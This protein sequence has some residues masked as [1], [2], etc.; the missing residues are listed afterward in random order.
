[1]NLEEQELADWAYRTINTHNR[2]SERSRWQDMFHV[3]ISDVGFCQ[4]FTRRMIVQEPETDE[5]DYSAAFLGTAIGDHVEAALSSAAPSLRRGVSLT[6][7]L[8]GDQGT[9]YITGHPD[10]LGDDIVIDIKTHA[11]LKLLERTGPTQQQL[12]QRH[13]Y[14]LGAHQ[15]GLLSVPLAEVKT[16]NLWFDRSGADH[17]AVAHVD[18]FNPDMVKA[19]TAWLDDVVYAVRYGEEASREPP[20]EFCERYCTRFTACRSRDT[21]V[22]G[23]LTDPEVLAAVD[24]YREAGRQESEAKRM[25]SQAQIALRGVQGSTGQYTVRWVTV[26]GGPVAYQRHEYERLSIQR[27]RAKK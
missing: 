17:A 15:S 21:D 22:H 4:E 24:L 12:F 23:L 6:A 18:T 25:R 7:Q 10:L 16:A 3:G 19:A 8:S 2:A 13:L 27:L 26:P 20:R 5:R 14:A 9:Y 11:G 1:M